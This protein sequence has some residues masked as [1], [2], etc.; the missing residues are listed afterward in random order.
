MGKAYKEGGIIL[1]MPVPEKSEAN[2]DKLV[3]RVVF[4]MDLDA[5]IDY[6]RYHIAEAYADATQEE[7]EEDWTLVFGDDI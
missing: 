5:L 4:D 6:A 2:I 3:E 7:W 1:L